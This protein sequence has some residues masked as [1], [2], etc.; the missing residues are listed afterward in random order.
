[1][2]RPLVIDASFKLFFVS[3]DLYLDFP[4]ANHMKLS[5]HL[6]SELEGIELQCS[7]NLP[8]KMHNEGELMLS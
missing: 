5:L 3:C 4:K 2:A 8:S 1:M 6:A 7:V